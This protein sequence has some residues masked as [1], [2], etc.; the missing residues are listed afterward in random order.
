MA[1]HYNPPF[2]AILQVDSEGKPRITLPWHEW[3]RRIGVATAGSVQQV[4][5]SDISAPDTE[6]ASKSGEDDGNVLIAVYTGSGNNAFTIY[7][8]DSSSATTDSPFVVAGSGGHW[9]AV[10]GRY[11]NEPLYINPTQPII[12]GTG[13]TEGDWKIIRDGNNLKIQVYTSGAWADTSEWLLAD[14]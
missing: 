7:L 12:W 2:E 10:G 6:L 13:T 4:N 14:Y 3:F 5:V 1:K 8:W 9:V 11:T